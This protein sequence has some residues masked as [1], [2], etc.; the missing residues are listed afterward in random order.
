MSPTVLFSHYL[1]SHLD[2]NQITLKAIVDKN[3]AKDEAY[4]DRDRFEKLSKE[5]PKLDRMRN[6]LDLDFGY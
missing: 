3:V 6:E 2:N 4:S 1:K 5:Y